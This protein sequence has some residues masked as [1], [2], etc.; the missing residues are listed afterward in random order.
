M[1]L[2][3]L[4]LWQLATF[5]LGAEPWDSRGYLGF[6]ASALALCALFGW[7]RPERAWCWALLVI[8][9]QVPVMLLNAA[10]R[11]APDGLVF[12]GLVYLALQALTGII[13]ASV[14]RHVRRARG[15]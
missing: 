13:V 2:S 3:G 8:F 5:V 6:Y 14:T 4:A 10:S 15:R 1:T 7:L 11:W 9:A 12:V